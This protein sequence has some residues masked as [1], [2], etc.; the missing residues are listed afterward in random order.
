MRTRYKVID[1][2]GY[3]FITS[4]IVEMIPA[5]TNEKY[6]QILIDSLKF[7]QKEKGLKIFFYVLLDNHFHLITSGKELSNIMSSLKRHTAQEIIQQLKLDRKEWLLNQFYYFKKKYKKESKYQIW[8]EGFHPQFMSSNEILN[9]KIEYIHYNPVKRGF[10]NKPE[11]WKYSS[12][13][14]KDWEG[15]EIIKLDELE[16]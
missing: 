11:C 12:A 9:Q 10:V 2:E 5:F 8:Q 16:I 7:C 6:F 4:S 15:N 3:Y 14:N 13:C 1:D